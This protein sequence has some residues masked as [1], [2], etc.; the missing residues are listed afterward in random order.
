[1][2]S[3]MRVLCLALALTLAPPWAAAETGDS[4][5]TGAA[6]DD[7]GGE[8]SCAETT[9]SG[10]CEGDSE[11]QGSTLADRTGEAGGCGLG[12][13]SAALLPGVLLL[14]SLR[15]RERRR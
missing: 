7:S 10:D 8:D 13:S 15:S 4:G 12:K 5:D 6:G 2:I 3:M 1:M 9:D 14:F 11:A